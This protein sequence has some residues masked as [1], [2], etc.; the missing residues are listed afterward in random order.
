MTLQE[1]ANKTSREMFGWRRHWRR[2]PPGELLNTWLLACIAKY[3]GVP[4]IDP[5]ELCPW[6]YEDTKTH[7]PGRALAEAIERDILLE[8]ETDAP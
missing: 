3:I 2:Y 5:K 7:D 8:R 1:R 4:G 6:R